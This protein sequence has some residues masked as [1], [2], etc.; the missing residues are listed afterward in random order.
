MDSCDRIVHFFDVQPLLLPTHPC[1]EDKQGST[2]DY[3]GYKHDSESKCLLLYPRCKYEHRNNPYRRY[4]QGRKHTART[5]K[6]LMAFKEANHLDNL[7]AITFVLP[8]DK[9]LSQWL[10]P[11]PGG[12]EMAWRLLPKFLDNCLARLMPEHSTMAVWATLHFWSTRDPKVFHFHFH[13]FLLNYVEVPAFD[14]PENGQTYELVERPFP[15]NED[16]KRTP[17]TKAQL[18]EL[19]AGSR[20][21]Q[22]NFAYYHRIDAPS[23]A[24]GKEAD[25]RVEYLSFSKEADRPKIINRLNYMKR[26]PIVDYAKASN[27]NHSYPWPTE[28]MWKY[29]TPMRTFGYAKRLKDLTGEVDDSDK[30]KLSPLTGKKM[31]YIGRF[32]REQVLEHAQ[33]QLG[34]LDFRKGKPLLGV[35]TEQELDWLKAVDYSEYPHLGWY[36]AHRD[37]PAAL[38]ASRAP[39]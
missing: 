29:T 33:G 23:L 16:G 15:I 24:E 32:T 9:E 8:L 39:P 38:L 12:R 36:K 14:D 31:E 20:R 26:H 34:R 4:R 5:F 25:L 1:F 27:K 10:G 22:A 35:L 13:L 18:A 28:L 19:R 3:A 21:L 7:K 37:D 11:Q 30:C 17:F 2:E 6:K